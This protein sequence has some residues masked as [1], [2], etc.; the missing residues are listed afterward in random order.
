MDRILA[1]PMLHPAGRWCVWLALL[2]VALNG[3]AQ[4][5]SSEAVWIDVR[6]AAEFRSGHLENAWNIPHTEIADRITEVV[7]NKDAEIQ[8][9]CGS[10]RRSEM[11]RETLEK[12]GYTRVTNAGAYRDL[13]KE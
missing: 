8:L 10:G 9:Y 1:A 4:N 12:L 3:M 6:S 13:V 11:A 2:V 5:E 7:S